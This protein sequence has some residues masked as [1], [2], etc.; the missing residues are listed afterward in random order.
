[1]GARE[2]RH[3]SLSPTSAASC[4]GSRARAD[5]QEGIQAGA[6]PL[7]CFHRNCAHTH[8][9]DDDDDDDCAMAQIVTPHVHMPHMHT[10]TLLVQAMPERAS[11][12]SYTLQ[13]S[14]VI[15]I[16]PA[17]LLYPLPLLCHIV[18]SLLS[19]ILDSSVHYLEALLTPNFLSAPRDA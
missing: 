12:P 6:T 17:H 18:L 2:T 15:K 4:C 7:P 13:N 10:H 16:S 19:P 5:R 1:M 14:R 9:D 11:H 3:S 8:P